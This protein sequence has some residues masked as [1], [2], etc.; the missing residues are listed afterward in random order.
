MITPFFV[1]IYMYITS[2]KERSIL[3]EIGVKKTEYIPINGSVMRYKITISN[4]NITLN[5]EYLKGQKNS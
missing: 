3:L 2:S 1:T 5:K 4:A